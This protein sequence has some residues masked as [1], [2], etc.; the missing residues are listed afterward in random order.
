MPRDVPAAPGLGLLFRTLPL[1]DPVRGRGLRPGNFLG[2]VFR[3]GAGTGR[4]RFD[5]FRKG[6]SFPLFGKT[7]DKNEMMNLEMNLKN[8]LE[9]KA[10]A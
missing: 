3:S 4:L 6:F 7:T 9:E 2:L 5:K 8:R 1:S 10:A